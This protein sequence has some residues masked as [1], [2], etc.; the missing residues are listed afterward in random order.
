V[1]ASAEVGLTEIPVGVV[2]HHLEVDNGGGIGLD[3]CVGELDSSHA[4]VGS[5]L[6][7]R[8]INND[9][10][11]WDDSE[12]DE[13]VKLTTKVDL[14]ILGAPLTGEGNVD[15]DGLASLEVRV[16]I[17]L[18]TK[19]TDVDIRILLVT[20]ACCDGPLIKGVAHHNQLLVSWSIVV[21]NDTNG[22]NQIPG[23]HI[24]GKLLSNLVNI[25]LG[26]NDKNGG[27]R[28]RHSV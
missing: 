22:S 17:G 18:E 7:G 15:D 19:S 10:L 6:F 2:Q 21:V 27:R 24:P 1:P 23:L 16:I 28:G 12:R 20:K 13:L 26:T 3:G 14:N 8:N 25:H 4:T 9:T 5:I 11:R